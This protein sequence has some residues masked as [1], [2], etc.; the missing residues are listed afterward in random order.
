MLR[1]HIRSVL[2][3]GE[4]L[5]STVILASC[6]SRG[7]RSREE[8]HKLESLGDQSWRASTAVALSVSTPTYPVREQGRVAWVVRR[9]GAS[10]QESAFVPPSACKG[11][12]LCDVVQ[13]I[14][15]RD[16][17]GAHDEH[18]DNQIEYFS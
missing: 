14:I 2:Q 11:R 6:Y 12:P 17:Y 13:R 5:K 3:L 9:I 10:P 4:A 16:K 8:G 15:V 7:P 1:A 18:A